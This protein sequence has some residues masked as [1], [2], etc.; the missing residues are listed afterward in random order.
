[1]EVVN[2]LREADSILECKHN[3]INTWYKSG[4][5]KNCIE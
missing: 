2:T 3:W 5:L 1:M 4:T